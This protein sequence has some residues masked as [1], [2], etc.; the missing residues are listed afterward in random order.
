MNQGDNLSVKRSLAALLAKPATPERQR[1]LLLGSLGLVL[2]AAVAHAIWY[3]R[4]GAFPV[5]DAYITLHNAIAFVQGRDANFPGISPFFG[6][7]SA[8]HLILV[9]ALCAVMPPAWALWT[10]AWLAIAL[11]CAGLNRLAV[12]FEVPSAVAA[13]LVF[14]GLVA[15]ETSYQLV[16]G[17]ETGLALAAVVWVLALHV[18]P[19]FRGSRLL[20]VLIGQLPFVRPELAVFGALL[21]LDRWLELGDE[22]RP[23]RRVLEDLGLA[24]GSASIWMVTYWITTGGPFP[25]SI[26]AKKNYFAEGCRPWGRKI[27]AITGITGHFL[28]M[29]GVSAL[30][31][32]LLAR[33]R[34]GRFLLYF[35]VLFMLAYYIQFPGAL[36]HYEHRYLYLFVPLCVFGFG[37]A[38]ES[39]GS[40]R[41]ELL[42][43]V[44]ALAVGN[45]SWTLLEAQEK[46]RLH[47]REDLGELRATADFV[48]KTV[49]PNEAV[50]VHDVG[51]I[52]TVVPNRLIDFVGLKTPRAVALHRAATWPTCGYARAIAVHQLAMETQPSY[53]VMLGTWD[54]IFRIV[55]GLV[56]LGWRLEPMRPPGVRYQVYRLRPPLVSPVR[57]AVPAEAP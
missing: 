19:A 49:S 30:G 22:P 57:V 29:M 52:S 36:N 28:R 23:A 33:E 43:V 6:A 1:V 18:D 25:P 10:A 42:F 17:L 46:L 26:V 16:N 54:R 13:S 8:V 14:L 9:T 32:L 38:W 51:Y 37:R 35:V 11:Y 55:P 31:L 24:L 20:P 15:G 2:A 21:L 4:A 3:G 44:L 39:L 41:R 27:R 53:L 12:L 50:L 7:T 45:G 40:R 47:L 56:S 48:K 5:D 34:T